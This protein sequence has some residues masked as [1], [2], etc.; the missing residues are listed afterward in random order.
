MRLFRPY[1]KEDFKT[2][3]RHYFRCFDFLCRCRNLEINSIPF[4]FAEKRTE[5]NGRVY[6]VN[7]STRETQ[8][9][10]PRMLKYV[11]KLS[12]QKLACQV[13][14]LSED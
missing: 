3:A 9:E 14:N 2:T 1:L 6:F 7:H 4:L 12:T 11:H 13:L 8:W 10:D 5:Q